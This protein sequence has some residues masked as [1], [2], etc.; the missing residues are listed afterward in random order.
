MERLGVK[1]PLLSSMESLKHTCS[2]RYFVNRV[3]DRVSFM[4]SI[5]DNNYSS[6]I[7]THLC[8]MFDVLQYLS[9]I[10]KNDN[11]DLQF[12]SLPRTGLPTH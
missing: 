3:T 11:D 7:I 12:L 8:K 10:I 4:S 2:H 9:S 6:D 5:V 1:D